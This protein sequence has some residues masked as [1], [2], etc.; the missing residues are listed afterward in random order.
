MA[1]SPVTQETIKRTVKG[2]AAAGV[3]VARVEVLPSGKVIVYTNAAAG[4]GS[5]PNTWDEGWS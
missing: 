5:A 1:K 2:V 4:E 3:P